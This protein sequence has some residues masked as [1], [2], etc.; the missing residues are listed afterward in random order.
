MA[1]P[2]ELKI[3]IPKTLNFEYEEYKEFESI[4]GRDNVSRELRAMMK[5]FIE[6]Q[7]K[8]EALNDSGNHEGSTIIECSNNNT[9]SPNL[10]ISNHRDLREF[11]DTFQS[12]EDISTL[13]KI[14]INSNSLEKLAH[15]R[16]ADLSTLNRIEKLRK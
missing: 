6:T 16:K 2:T 4:V 10:C 5:K 1:R 15:S 13:A 8:W 7:K 14:E 9:T 12:T 3:R 11:I